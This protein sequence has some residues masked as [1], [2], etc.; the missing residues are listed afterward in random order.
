MTVIPDPLTCCQQLLR[1]AAIGHIFGYGCGSNFRSEQERINR[2]ENVMR[3]ER[4]VYTPRTPTE[5]FTYLADFTNTN[6]WDPG[7]VS[8]TRTSGDGGV[9][10]T[11]RNISQFLGRKTELT[12][13]T[14]ILRPDEFVELMGENKTL[15]AHDQMTITSEGSGSRVDYVAE[16]EF[17]GLTKLF[18]PLLRPA[19]NKLGDDAQKGMTQ[20][21]R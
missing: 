3:L 19:F 2:S 8:T 17:K 7:T 5:T 11:Y 9:G 12:Y 16:F 14:V 1:A 6:E 4:T 20:A 18:A 13:T 15:V 10:S 21:L